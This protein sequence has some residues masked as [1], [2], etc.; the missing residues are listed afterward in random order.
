MANTKISA[1][2]ADT[3]PTAD[4]LV[5]TVNDPA[6][7][8]AT[9]KA[10][11]T[12]FT[13]AIPEVIGDSGSGGTKGLVPAP[14]AGDAAANK[15]LH[16]DGT[17]KTPAGSGAIG[18]S[19]G[20]TDNA[21]LRADG[22]GGATAQSSPIT[23]DD[24]GALT[25]PEIAAPSTPAAGKV[26]VYAKSDN[27]V[28][29]KGE[30][31]V[32]AEL[33]GGAGTTINP[34]DNTI[35]RRSSSAA[36][37]DSF[38]THDA[39]NGWTASSGHVLINNNTNKILGFGTSSILGGWELAGV[40]AMKAVAD[41]SHNTGA[42]LSAFN[43][44]P[45]ETPTHTIHPWSSVGM[46][47]RHVLDGNTTIGNPGQSGGTGTALDGYRF[48]LMLVQ[49]GTGGRTVTWGSDYRF[50]AGVAPI[51]TATA[52]KADLYEFICFGDIAYCLLVSQNL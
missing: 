2:T 5:V 12:N 39:G 16:A 34:T 46:N 28:Y 49:D 1:L 21:L 22:T 14:A 50:P 35:P 40:G 29:R 19:T 20:S 10:T 27:K 30:D 15:F 47:F 8:P 52:N 6:G 26:A 51:M 48:V 37:A 42:F 13:K 38:L 18:G 17:F 44:A 4:D 31:G 7:T 45:P 3:A 33:G 9:R 24:N 41:S 25:L 11:I 32:E 36:F 43:T 23:V